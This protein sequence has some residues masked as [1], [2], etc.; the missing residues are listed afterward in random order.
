MN[1]A[2]S[3]STDEVLGELIDRI[4]GRIQAGKPLNLECILQDHPERANELRE[5]L[6]A[7]QVMAELG[8]ALAKEEITPG[9]GSRKAQELGTLGDFRILR[10][11]GR[12]GMG[13]VYEAEQ[14]SLGR[15][16]ALKVLP[17][18]ATMDPRNL[19]RFRNEAQ[20]AAHLHHNH[21]VPVFGVGC[22]R[23]VH[24]YAMQFI[25]GQSLAE[26]IFDLR[27]Q[28]RPETN[29]AQQKPEKPGE[30]RRSA[31][32]TL[33][34][35]SNRAYF[36]QMAQLG[37]QAAE[38]LDYA[39]QRGIV[40]R[41][42]KPANLLLDAGGNLW[43][44]DFG[45]ANFQ[46]NDVRLTR[47]GDLLGTIR[48]MSPEQA[49]PKRLPMGPRSDIYSLGATLYELLTLEPAFSAVDK[50][51]LL[52]QLAYQEPRAPRSVNRAIPPELDTI[53]LKAMAK[54]PDERYATAQELTEDLRRFLDDQ[55]IKA[56]RPTV[57]Q[58]W[59]KWT[60]RH[61]ALVRAAVG[62]A[63]VS[64]AALV[65]ALLLVLNEK[66]KAFQEKERTFRAE[67]H[68][69][70][71]SEENVR[72]AMQTLDQI[73][74]G[75]VERWSPR[76]TSPQPQDRELLEKALIFYELFAQ[77]NAGNMQARTETA[78]AYL[79]T[80]DVC[81]LLGQEVKAED[82]YQ[83]AIVRFK[84]LV[85]AFPSEPG[86]RQELGRCHASLGAILENNRRLHR[87]IQSYREAISHRQKL[88]ESFPANKDYGQELADSWHRL[89]VVFSSGDQVKQAQAAFD[90]A[91]A[92]QKR[93][94]LDFPTDPKN[95]LALASMHRDL[96]YLLW[97]N[98]GLADAERHLQEGQSLLERGVGPRKDQDAKNQ[99]RLA[100]LQASFGTMFHE[101]GMGEQ[102]EVAL[103]HSIKAWQELA[104][105]FPNVPHFQLEL[106]DSQHHLCGLYRDLR[107][108]KEAAEMGRKA[109]VIL[110][111]LTHKWPGQ[112]KVRDVLGE[113]LSI[114]GILF[115]EAYHFEEAEK[116]YRRS[117]ALRTDLV[118]EYPHIP[119]YRRR[120]ACVHHNLGLLLRS[121]RMDEAEKEHRKAVDVLT[122]LV[123]EVPGTAYRYRLAMV[124]GDLGSLLLKKRKFA[125]AE[126]SL[127][128]ARQLLDKELAKNPHMLSFRKTQSQ[129][130]RD[131]GVLLATTNRHALADKS[132]RQSLALSANDPVTLNN[133]A[134][135]LV[136]CP[137]TKLRNP[138][139]AL[140]LVTKALCIAPNAS[141][142]WNPRYW[143]N[144]L[145]VAHYRAGNWQLAKGALITST[146]LNSGGS[147]S[148][149]Y[150][151]AMTC[152]QL[153]EE[154]EA[155][156]WFKRAEDWM[157]SHHL[158]DEELKRFQKEAAK[159]LGP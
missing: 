148:D 149:W 100:A 88:K 63:V 136:T 71:N 138:R 3:L 121:S 124:Y 6:P 57:A 17:F 46:G 104:N 13:I 143:W 112:P 65:V 67:Q 92:L 82:A 95:R 47:T 24:Y 116:L 58:R 9:T 35:S 14:L 76:D 48:Y 96:A 86:H 43:I 127:E 137:D 109:L 110:E 120:L 22:E 139:E 159:V 91:L 108:S 134:W 140:E 4:A 1:S 68:H 59:L 156:M 55:P 49:S 145:G 53:V 56:R 135:L 62:A 5:L 147:A 106:A 16:V 119:E 154:K 89:A 98:G 52:V 50:A 129:V 41:D 18:A 111:P 141:C 133:L 75:V 12:G 69:R 132:Y 117:L 28:S 125:D 99:A 37:I 87:A 126:T 70:R 74:L 64:V 105:E 25:E 155:S 130:L 93:L 30:T 45:L 34:P 54:N 97:K 94:V 114:L 157:Q 150:F 151:L 118:R 128:A 7:I 51:E 23:G 77:K 72:L 31:I 26:L 73:Y 32:S 85:D 152:R 33:A 83:Q 2:P 123:E 131:L 19:E 102:A 90:Q 66:N 158:H 79:R 80:G 15:R 20:A 29:P 61:R 113:H 146:K 101:V 78:R 10:E 8:H 36:R 122:A 39:H 115:L 103:R 11:V 142:G 107:R 40:H 144:T 44:T 38:A 21:I 42:I 153:G 27:A 84:D 81:T 60:R